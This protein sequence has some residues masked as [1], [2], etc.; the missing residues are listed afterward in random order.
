MIQSWWKDAII[1]AV[2]VERFHDG[3]GDGVG[4][5]KGL[6]SKLHYI[7]DLGVTCI[8]LLPFYPS[9]EED[10]GYAITDYFRIDSRFGLFEDFLDFVHRAGEYGIRVIIDLV[11]HHTSDQHPWFQAARYNEKS[12]YRDYYVWAHHPPPVAPGEGTIFPGEED[13]VWTYDEVARAFYHHRFYHFEPGLNQANPDVRDEIMRIMDFWLSFGIAGFRVDAAAHLLENP[14]ATPSEAE[15]IPDILRQMYKR[16]TTFKPDVLML[17]EVDESPQELEKFF[18]GSRLNMMFNFLLDNYLILALAEERAEPIQRGLTLL[19]QAPSNGQ[20][21]NF[22]RN[23][24]EADLERLKPEE[25]QAVFRAFAPEENMRIYGRGL[26]R[27]LAPML[28]GDEQRLKMAFSLLFA[29]PGAPLIVYGD[30]IGMGEDLSQPGR[31]AVRSPMQWDGSDN[32]GFSTQK[33]LAQ[34]VIRDGPFG[35][36]RVNVEEQ[37]NRPDSLLSFIRRLTKLRRL[38]KEIQSGA[39]AILG[40]KS[41]HVLALHYKSEDT[42]LIVLHNLKGEKAK[43]EIDLPLDV[44]PLSSLFG[45]GGPDFSNGRLRLELEPYGIRWLGRAK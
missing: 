42:P 39:Y 8:W 24:D 45:D 5:F 43:V 17:G 37:L 15:E 11:V 33:K 6:T 31:N 41:E 32:G 21:A 28:G 27:R 30:E 14:L 22:L 2:D 38:H 10:N 16:A 29:M 34:P 23:L 9:T 40:C 1:Y 18:D 25:L 12:R 7:A 36:T 3:N 13:T 4:D 19:P 26:R 44:G 35:F 20:W